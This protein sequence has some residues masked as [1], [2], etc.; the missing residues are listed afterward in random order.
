MGV[1]SNFSE[2]VLSSH[3]A[4]AAGSHLIFPLLH[5]FLQDSWL[6]WKLLEDPPVSTPHLSVGVPGLQPCSTRLF[7]WVPGTEL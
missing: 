7:T 4:E 1:A 3:H 6:A 2:L 5:G